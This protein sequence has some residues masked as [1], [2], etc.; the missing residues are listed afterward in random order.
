MLEF[1]PAAMVMDQMEGLLAGL[2]ANSGGDGAGGGGAVGMSFFGINAQGRSVV[3]IFDVSLSVLNKA[4]KAGISID[5]IKQETLALI[6]GLSINTVFDLFQFSRYYQPFAGRLVAPTEANKAAVKAWLE[7]DFQS[8]GSLG[9]NDVKGVIAPSSGEDNGIVFVL[10]AALK[11]RPDVIFL[12]SDAS[13][14][15][16]RYAGQVPWDEV[17]D[18][19]KRHEKSGSVAP[20]INFIGFQMK[21]DDGKAMK[22]IVRKTAGTLRELE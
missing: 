13:F 16:E 6:E 11:A 3:V 17:E 21:E 8:D 22:K 4:K 14:Q 20:K 1:D 7:K 15:S 12:I 5:R 2:G 19:I 18:V 10:Q 9:R